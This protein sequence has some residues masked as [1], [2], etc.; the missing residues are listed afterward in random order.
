MD[1]WIETYVRIVSMVEELGFDTIFYR[2]HCDS[3]WKLLPSLARA[4]P[5]K[6]AS[7]FFDTE[8]QREISV[9]SHFYT[10]AGDLLPRDADSW[11]IA[12]AMQHHGVATRLLDWT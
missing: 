3:D 5:T 11:T 6:D 8:E 1:P 7:T 4:R 10:H 9:Y 2:G 12:F